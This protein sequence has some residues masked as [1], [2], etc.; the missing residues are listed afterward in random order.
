MTIAGTPIAL[1]GDFFTQSRDVHPELTE[2]DILGPSEAFPREG[3][4]LAHG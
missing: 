3:F 2:S 4:F 1:L